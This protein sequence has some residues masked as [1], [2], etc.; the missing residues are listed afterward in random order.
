LIASR[1][2]ETVRTL[3]YN[4]SAVAP[5]LANPSVYLWTF[6]GKRSNFFGVSTGEEVRRGKE[7]Q[8]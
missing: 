8:R 4:M 3:D 2:S 6:Q 7:E 5:D 1:S